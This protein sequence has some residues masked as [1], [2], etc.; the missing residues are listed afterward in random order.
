MTQVVTQEVTFQ[1]NG[2]PVSVPSQSGQS[3]LDLL[4]NTLQLKATR[5]GCGQ[6]QCGAC[7]VM[8]DG[9]A[10][11]ACETPVW[12]IEGKS[13][14][15]LEGLG[16]RSAPHALQTAFIEEQAMQCGF[17]TSGILMSAAALLQRQ[18]QPSRQDIVQAIDGHLCRCGAHNRVVRAIEKAAAR[19]ATP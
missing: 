3:L 11:A 5:M 18:P 2:H 6:G 14:T 4:R 7:R 15:T 10:V 17:C 16:Q 8:L 1:L 12:A 13:V 9:H 19:L